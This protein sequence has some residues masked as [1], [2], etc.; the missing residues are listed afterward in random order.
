M[1]SIKMPSD[2]I[3]KARNITIGYL[4]ALLLIAVLIVSAYVLTF[5]ALDSQAYDS[6]VVNLSGRQRMLSQ[7]L[8]KELIILVQSKDQETRNNYR[9]LLQVTLAS[10][11]RVHQGL[12]K[13]DQQLRLPGNNSLKINTLFAE[14]E[15]YYKGIKNGAS[16]ILALDDSRVAS[17]SIQTP[18]VTNIVIGSALFL[19]GMDTIV[20]QYDRE[21]Q[22]RVDRLKTLETY[23]VLALIL[24]LILE[25]LLIFRPMF[26]RIK[27]AY[28][29]L[30]DANDSLEQR[31]EVRTSELLEANQQLKHEIKERKKAEASLQKAYSELQEAQGHLIQ[32]EKMQLVG[33]LASGVAHEVKNPL[34]I[35][36]QSAAVLK[37]RM[38]TTDK[39]Q[40]KALDY[41]KKSV[42][43]ADEAIKGLLD[44]ASTNKL[45][46]VKT[47]I[48]SVINRSLSLVE[49][50]L[51]TQGI[52]TIKDLNFE[53]PEIKID[54]NKIE[55]V[56]VNLILNA[57]HAMPEGGMLTVT[58][59]ADSIMGSNKTQSGIIV[60]IEDTGVGIPK[61]NIDNI[62]EPFFTTRRGKGG[63]G[64]G[65]PVVKN[66]MEMHNG[67]IEIQN[68]E[69]RGV[70]VT[71]MFN[72]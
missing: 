13:G 1:I 34:S 20:F 36:L 71:L 17:L 35:I 63:T 60:R 61:E 65:L 24:L 22:Q 27:A 2:N 56:F 28:L 68:R 31:V 4:T 9:Q 40:L 64:M 7:K 45:E 23:I 21:A 39:D 55:Q 11:L 67:R 66:I 38:T 33:R 30:Q 49:Y 6:R 51:E 8:T 70:E 26:R 3:F 46:I 52:Q 53:L 19:K 50:Q 41:I 62:F 54:A 44:F 47:D 48:N 57:T 72:P 69:D 14:I 42:G 59:C 5:K 43:K 29:G 58:S 37:K 25:A 12:Q 16:K 18:L 32:A 10:W 15:P